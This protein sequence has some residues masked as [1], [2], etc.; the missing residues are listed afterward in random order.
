MTYDGPGVKEKIKKT[1]NFHDRILEGEKNCIFP[2][3]SRER[4]YIKFFL[5]SRPFFLGRENKKNFLF[6]LPF[7]GER[8]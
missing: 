5:F 2:S 7:I 8:K 4:I 1:L 3:F 6:S